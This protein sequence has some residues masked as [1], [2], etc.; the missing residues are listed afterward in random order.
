VSLINN[1]VILG[2]LTMDAANVFFGWVKLVDV[3]TEHPIE[4][5]CDPEA[6]AAADGVKLPVCTDPLFL[7]GH[8]PPRVAALPEL[9]CGV[10]ACCD[11]ST[12]IRTLRAEPAMYG[13]M[14]IDDTFSGVGAQRSGFHMVQFIGN[15]E[16]AIDWL[17][18]EDGRHWLRDASN[19]FLVTFAAPS[20]F[21]ASAAPPQPPQANADSYDPCRDFPDH[22]WRADYRAFVDED[23]D[24]ITQAELKKITLDD[25]KHFDMKAECQSLTDQMSGR[26]KPREQE[27]LYEAD[28]IKALQQVF[29]AKGDPSVPSAYKPASMKLID[30]LYR[31]L[32]GPIFHMKFQYKR[33]RPYPCCNVVPLLD[34]GHPFFPA[35]AGYPAGHATLVFVAADI[36]SAVFPKLRKE[37]QRRAERVA[38]NRIV[39]GFHFK[40]DIEAGRVLANKLLP[41][42]H[43]H[44]EIKKLVEKAK[45]EWASS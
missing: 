35:H 30:K 11:R 14:R 22:L 3:D 18:T 19:Y 42:I 13:V 31:G 29:A 7:S 5:K 28:S 12:R 27:I 24:F 41:R 45:N 33:A 43:A 6:G 37:F 1:Q 20:L 4:P 40:T 2:A 39:A 32:R 23:S 15:R 34:P 9:P 25:P 44:G 10:S 36:F 16:Q 26:N 8:R 17:D 38:E 21:A